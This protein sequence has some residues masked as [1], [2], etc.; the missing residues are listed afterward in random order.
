VESCHA[1]Q[2]RR[3]VGAS[4]DRRKFSNKSIRAHARAGWEV[5][6]VNP[7]GGQIEGH[8]VY[9]SLRDIP[10]PIERVTLY[11]P[12]AVGVTVLP[13]IAA[14]QPAEFFVNPGAESAALLSKAA[15]LGLEP[16]LACSIID[17]G[18]SPAEFSD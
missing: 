16:T 1:A 5:F 15:R 11:L 2:N 6:P 3:C 7:K 18:A 8:T 13:D 9:P 17:V 10:V 4:A 14:A 12:P